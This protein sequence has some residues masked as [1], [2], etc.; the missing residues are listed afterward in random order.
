MSWTAGQTYYILLDPEGS[1]T[2]SMTF[3]IDCPSAASGPCTS[4]TTIGGCAMPYSFTVSGTGSWAT[5]PCGFSSPGIEM[6]YSFTATQTGTYTMDITSFSGSYVDLGFINATSGCSSTG[7]TCIDDILF[8]GTTPGF[9]LVAGQTYYFLFDP[10]T[11]TGNTVTFDLNCPAGAPVTAGDCQFAVNICDNA[12]FAV[13]PNGY[14]AIDEIPISGTVSNPYYTWGDAVLSPWGTDNYGC[15][16]SGETN[17]TWMIINISGTGILE[18][19]FGGGGAQAGYYDWIMWPY[20]SSA[21]NGVINNTLAPVRCNWNYDN[22]GGT[23]LANT[24]PGGADPGN[25]EPGLAVTA[26]Q[27]YLICFSN[28]SSVTTNVPLDFF[29]TAT[30][31]CTPLSLELLSLSAESMPTNNMVK[32]RVLHNSEVIGY[33][34]Q[35]S[36]NGVDFFLLKHLGNPETSGQI[37]W[38][39]EHQNPEIQTFY[40]VV[41]NNVNGTQSASYP[42]VLKRNVGNEVNV[43]PNPSNGEIT[44]SGME[45]QSIEIYDAMGKKVQSLQVS[46]GT[47]SVQINSLSPGIYQILIISGE[48]R[49]IKKL[50]VE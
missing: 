23:G 18:F 38:L 50:L 30:V 48:Q 2:Y 8:T 7:W 35:Y 5:S 13:D 34:L 19:S 14:G 12:N 37:E 22:A 3:N 21:C 26:G 17:S 33:E 36:L 9:N 41:S 45:L 20:N 32:T 47:S 39:T 24:L 44:I 43:Y 49:I 46:G 10:E 15:L 40:R 4:I 42:V 1:G 29:G 27:Q 6:I 11:T 25:Y 31:S 28:Y 16:Q